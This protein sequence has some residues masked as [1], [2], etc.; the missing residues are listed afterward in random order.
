MA[1]TAEPTPDA[2]EPEATEPAP[3]PPAADTAP[4]ETDWQ[5]EAE[6]YKALARKHEDRAKANAKAEKELEQLRQQ[7]MSDTEK[8]IAVAKQEARTEALR[9]FGAKVVDAEVRAAV[10]GRNV[11]ADALL[12]GLDRAR[13]LDDDGEP[14]RDAITAWVDRIAPQPAESFPD[15]GQGARGGTGAIT[16]PLLRDLTNL[17]RGGR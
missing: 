11:D 3:E 8:A 14:D 12:E 13:F 17:A 6:K 10:A 15:L 1:D 4:E 9:E 7:S 16:D 2:P 5:K